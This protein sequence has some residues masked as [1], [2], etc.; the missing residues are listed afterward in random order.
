MGNFLQA[1]GNRQIVDQREL[2]KFLKVW[3]V[4]IRVRGYSQE[5]QLAQLFLA[6]N[7]TVSIS[8]RH[9]V[10]TLSTECPHFATVFML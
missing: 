8:V 5:L 10:C 4:T 7:D 2:L 3:L 1:Y 6:G 9:G